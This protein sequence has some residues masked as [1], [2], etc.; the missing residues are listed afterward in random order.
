VIL[1]LPCSRG[2]VDLSLYEEESLRSEKLGDIEAVTEAYIGFLVHQGYEVPLC[3]DGVQARRQRQL[4]KTRCGKGGGRRGDGFVIWLMESCFFDSNNLDAVEC[5]T[6]SKHVF[7][8][9]SITQ[10]LFLVVTMKRAVEDMEK[11]SKR[12]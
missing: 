2:F 8:I 9:K 4:G 11:T 7:E 6:V 1:V 3:V 5:L 12:V 10:Q